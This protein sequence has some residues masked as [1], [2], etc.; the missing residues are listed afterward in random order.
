V[1]SS[2]FGATTSLAY[3]TLSDAYIA[4]RVAAGYGDYISPDLQV[5]ASTC[6]FPEQTWF[7]KGATHSNWTKGENAL[8]YT[9]TTS[10]KVLTADDLEISR[11]F[12]E[13]NETGEWQNMTAENC[14]T[15]NWDATPEAQH[16][17]GFIARIRAFIRA[18]R[19]WL[20]QLKVIIRERLASKD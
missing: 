15:Y 20:S 14:N 16:P 19:V 9:V 2:S 12:V 4:S 18:L 10:E 6:F 8:I 11:F 17:Q 1:Y 13:D 5:D 7:A 3:D